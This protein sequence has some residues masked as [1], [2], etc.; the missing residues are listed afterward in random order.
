[1]YY[2][3]SN[4]RRPGSMEPDAYDLNKPTRVLNETSWMAAQ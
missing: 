3:N 4:V 1:M 2:Q